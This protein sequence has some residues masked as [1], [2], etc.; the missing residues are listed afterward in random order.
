MTRF[1]VLGGFL[2]RRARLVVVAW[3]LIVFVLAGQGRSLE[4]NLDVRP[5]FAEGTQSKRAFE[6]SERQFSSGLTFTVMLR[7]PA[8]EVERQGRLLVQRLERGGR[9]LVLTADDGGGGEYSGLRPRPGVMGLVVRREDPGEA[10]ARTQ[11]PPVERLIARTVRGP[12]EASMAGLPVLFESVR[13][14]SEKAGTSGELIAMPILLLVLLFVFRSVLAALVPLVV[15]GTVVVAG[16]GVLNLLTG[17]V[18]MDLFAMG[19]VGMLGLALGVDY[20]LLT[21][22]RFREERA[23]GSDDAVAIATTV[24]GT[25]RAIVPAA[26][27]LLIAMAAAVLVYP[28]VTTKSI[29]VAVSAVTVLSAISA[30]CVVPSVLAL[31]G[32]N[33]DRWSLRERSGAEI[34]PLRWSRRMIAHPG[35][36]IGIVIVLLSFSGLAFGL[37]SGLANISLLPRDD[38]GRVKQEAME[39]EFGPGWISPME[40]VVNGRDRPMTSPRRLR[41]LVEFEQQVKSDPGVDTVVGFTQ[42]E[43]GIRPLGGLGD[44]LIAQ[45]RGTERLGKGI[46]RLHG[47]AVQNTN[48]LRAA[49]DGARAIHFGLGATHEGAQRLTEGLGSASAGSAQLEDGLGSASEGGESLA[50]GTAKA[51]EGAG[52]L[53]EGL[54][55]AREGTGEITATAHLLDN[56]MR[57]GEA[58]LDELAAPVGATG[59]Q[60]S[61][62]WSALQR[63]TVGRGDPAYAAALQAVAE[64]SRSLTGNDVQT[65]EQVDPAYG[66]VAE[67]IERAD[68]QFGVGRYLTGQIDEGGSKAAE[69]MDKLATA[70]DRLDRGLRRLQAGSRR[71]ATGIEQLSQ[72]SG[73]L[74]PGVAR[75][76]EGAERLTG[77]LEQLEGGSGQLADGLSSGGEQS[78]LLSGGL[79]RIETGLERRQAAEGGGPE[80]LRTQSPNLFDGGYFNLAVLAGSSGKRREQLG[81]LLSIDDGGRVARVLVI[82][83]DP[84]ATAEVAATGRRLEADAAAFAER[85]GAEVVVGGVAPSLEDINEELRSKAIWLRLTLSLVSFLILIPVTRSLTIAALAAVLNL[86]TVSACFGVLALLFND[87][88]LGGPGYV[89][90]AILHASMIVMFGLAIDYEVFVFSRMR[91]EY[92]RTGS[93]AA[94]L[95]GGLDRTAHVITGAAVIMIAVFLAFSV[96]EVIT[97][98]NFGI[99]QALGVFIDA[100]LIR[101]V[102]IP[103]VMTRLGKWS[104]WMPAW[105]DRL[106]PG[107]G[108][109]AGPVE[110]P[111]G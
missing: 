18:E 40:I 17:A 73:A 63:M 101:L 21:I 54:D 50:E 105:L 98:R 12:V 103:A 88:L 49:A 97:L 69:G 32:D 29:A 48:G 2:V 14:A 77:A 19:I 45:Q 60:L 72:G 56:A 87:S 36:V 76:G 37:D 34:A 91:E 10:D 99:A 94:A 62:A 51:S 33:L 39:R 9:Y 27:G 44:D 42:I 52:R 110:R 107:G 24:A 68:G 26:C 79:R 11:L 96:S 3:L 100:F 31:L 53:A 109:I 67:G 108:P 25:G 86:L 82:P 93:P 1:G 8:A 104:W 70:S 78:E 106:L 38:P 83:R 55:Q 13:E 74:A 41:D 61:A 15:G 59:E 6:L 64:A 57:S 23:K 35:A 43:R 95:Q 58:R 85:S 90:A 28:S 84:P 66:G 16:R 20:S 71:L 4:D 81:I 65:G 47:G 46:S 75:I 22:S 80:A 30:L 89:D 5:S 102:V 92:V 7:G 111:A